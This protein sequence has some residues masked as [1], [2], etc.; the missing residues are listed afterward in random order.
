MS[1]SGGR[2]VGAVA[3]RWGCQAPHRGARG[4]C[5]APHL[6]CAQLDVGA[7][8]KH[9]A[10]NL[11]RLAQARQLA[12]LADGTLERAEVKVVPHRK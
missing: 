7:V 5:S 1:G 9:V 12:G 11:F 2:R 6:I 8:D 4:A 3:A 10:L